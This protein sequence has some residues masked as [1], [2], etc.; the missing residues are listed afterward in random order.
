MLTLAILMIVVF[1]DT[2]QA[3]ESTGTDA[4]ALDGDEGGSGPSPPMDVI[5]RVGS[6]TKVT[7]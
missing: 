6:G 5:L 2:A 3:K 7:N 1:T 4:K